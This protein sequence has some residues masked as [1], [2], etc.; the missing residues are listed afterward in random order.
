MIFF[1]LPFGHLFRILSVL[2][3]AVS[4]VN[5]KKLQILMILIN[6]QAKTTI[7]K[8]VQVPLK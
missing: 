2:F 7:F 1:E 5:I 4:K 3:I 8:E 6:F